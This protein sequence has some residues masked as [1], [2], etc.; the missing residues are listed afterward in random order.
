MR[1]A[2]ITVEDCVAMS[3]LSKAEV[4]AIAEHEHL[5]EAQAVALGHY[6]LHRVHGPEKIR[7]MIEDDIRTAMKHGATAHAGV[8]LRA[9][10]Q[11][12]H[13]FPEGRAVAS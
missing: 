12:L 5:G 8:L 10:R 4:E 11:F 3:G 13:D 1:G 6:L 7:A 2:M 9:L